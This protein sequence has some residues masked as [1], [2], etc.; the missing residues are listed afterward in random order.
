MRHNNKYNKS[1]GTATKEK[2]NTARHVVVFVMSRQK[3]KK[4]RP[5]KKLKSTAN[6]NAKQIDIAEQQLQL[7]LL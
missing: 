4:Q 3:R 7:Q 2:K 6:E 1:C 5:L